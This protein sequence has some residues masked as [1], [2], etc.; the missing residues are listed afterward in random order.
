MTFNGFLFVGTC[1]LD[2][3]IRGDELVWLK[4]VTV[5]IIIINRFLEVNAINSL[6]QDTGVF[7]GRFRENIMALR[8]RFFHKI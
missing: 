2:F 5:L 6:A 8:K 1:L 4:Q 7:I 3:L